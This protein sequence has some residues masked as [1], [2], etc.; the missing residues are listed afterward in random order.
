MSF[1]LSQRSKD[2]IIGIHP[3]LILITYR[4]IEITKVDFGIPEFGGLRT[5]ED[6]QILFERGV[7]KADGIEKKSNHQSGNAVDFFP[8]VSGAADYSYGQCA[9]IACAFFQAAM[10]LGVKI[11]WGGLFRSFN[12][13]PHIELM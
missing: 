11:R 4:A 7:S 10:E 6:Q 2:R 3:D 5:T 9:N 8:Y 1:Y 12:D 13:K